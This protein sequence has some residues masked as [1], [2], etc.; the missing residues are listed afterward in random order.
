VPAMTPLHRFLLN[1]TKRVLLASI[2]LLLFA[3]GFYMQLAANIGLF[4]WAALNQGL[5]LTLP[6]TFGQASMSV[7]ALVTAS[8]LL[9]GESIGLGAILSIVLMGWATDLLILL[10]PIPYQ[11][12]FLP[13]LAVLLLGT[14]ITSIGTWSYMLA[15]LSCGPRD[16]FMVALGK[17]LPRLS[18]GTVSILI[19]LLVTLIAFLLGA[20]I[21]PGTLVTL[22]GTGVIMDLVFKIVRFEPRDVVH[23]SLPGTIAA[24]LQA[25]KETS[26]SKV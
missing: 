21:G 11:S 10:E 6:I 23:E 20:Q 9:M 1:R 15:G 12:Q 19:N 17:R 22:F 13:G 25:L 18:I 8:A 3:V 24:F 7:S 4:A 5:S 16:A 14:V 2:G 26:A